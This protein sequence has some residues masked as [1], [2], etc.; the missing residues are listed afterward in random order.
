MAIDR[1]PPSRPTL[2]DYLA[3]DG[4]AESLRVYDDVDQADR[5][6]VAAIVQEEFGTEQLDLVIDDC[7][8]LYAPTCASFNELFPRLRPGGVYVIEDWSWAHTPGEEHDLEGWWPDEV[9]LTRLVFELVLAL[10]YAPGVISD[11]AVHDRSL[12]VTR[13]AAEIHPGQFDISAC[14]R[15]RGRNLLARGVDGETG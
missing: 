3:R 1:K 4:L 2:G 8:H 5:E 9:P 11:L 12:R 6:R 15:S 13:G 14:A 7:S 10:P